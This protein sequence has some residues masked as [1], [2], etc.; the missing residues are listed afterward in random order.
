MINYLSLDF[1]SWTFPNLTEFR[2]LNSNERKFLDNGY[3]RKSAEIILKILKKHDTKIT[4]F[5][6]GQLYEWYPETIEKIFQE[7]HEI[8]FHTYSHDILKTKETLIK[9]LEK[10]KR[11]LNKFKPIGFRAPNIMLSKECLLILKEY[12]FKYDSSTYGAGISNRNNHIPIEF[13]VSTYGKVP[14]G[15][16]YFIAILGNKI[17]WFYRRINKENRPVIAF[18]HNWQVIKPKHATFPCLSYIIK[19]PYYLPYTFGVYS[20]LEFLLNNFSFAPM[21]NLLK[22]KRTK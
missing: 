12:G 17:E 10:S 21:K 6:L 7:G 22:E 16:G 15:S 5:V 8:A 4:F 13:P 11:F 1:E 3:V 9:S 2:K 19:H 20:T 14:I 18:I